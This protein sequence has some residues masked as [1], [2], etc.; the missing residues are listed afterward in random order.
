MVDWLQWL[1]ETQSIIIINII[2]IIFI[3]DIESVGV[4]FIS[5]TESVCAIVQL[6]L[7]LLK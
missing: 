4:L 1:L 2:I 3:S 5:H 6:V 7:Q